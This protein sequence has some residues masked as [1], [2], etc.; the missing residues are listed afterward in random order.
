MVIKAS[1]SKLK[2]G[3]YAF[4]KKD[5]YPSQIVQRWASYRYLFL[6]GVPFF[7]WLALKNVSFPNVLEALSGLG[8]LGI[9]TLM[10]VNILMA[11]AMTSRWWLII[12]ALGYNVGYVFHMGYR[13]AANAVSYFTPGPQFGGEPLQ[14]YLLHRNHKVPADASTVSVAMEKLMELTANFTFLLIGALCVIRLKLFQ[15]FL[16]GETLLIIIVLLTVPVGILWAVWAGKKPFSCLF[17]ILEKLFSFKGKEETSRSMKFTKSIRFSEDKAEALFRQKPIILF[18]ATVFSLLHWGCILGEFW[19]IYH[20]IGVTLTAIQLVVIVTVARLAFL[21]PLP[22][23]AGALEASQVWIV[24]SFGFNPA[25][26]LCACLIMR[27]RDLIFGSIGLWL[28]SIFMVS[29][30]KSRY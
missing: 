1:H 23:G 19:L 16:G 3:S 5:L 13:T 4:G 29:A 28:T 20:L 8:S 6:L 14:V 7:L 27:V 9:A 12:H 21:T 15:G 11:F 26:G 30:G 25:L 22:G 10:T 17:L 18:Q 2:A 24:T